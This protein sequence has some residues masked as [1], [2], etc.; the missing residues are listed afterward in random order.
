[1][2]GKNLRHRGEDVPPPQ[3]VVLYVVGSDAVLA[4]EV[5]QQEWRPERHELLVPVGLSIEGHVAEDVY[6]YGVCQQ[7][8]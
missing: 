8:C 7:V 4:T 1:M 5:H 3:L 2:I 6:R